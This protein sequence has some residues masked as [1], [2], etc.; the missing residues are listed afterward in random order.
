MNIM[1]RIFTALILFSITFSLT[2][3]T[4]GIAGESTKKFIKGNIADKTAAVREAS[5]SEVAW[6]SSKAIEFCLENKDILGSD[7]ELDGLAVAAVLSLSQETLKNADAETKDKIIS[8][9]TSLFIKFNK[10]STVQIAVIT[11]LV[12]L[13]DSL[14]S[15]AFTIVLNDFI[16]TNDIKTMDSGVFKASITALE[17]IG[18]SESF[19]ILYSMANDGRYNLYKREIETAA[20]SLIPTSMDE[21]I[22]L[23]NGADMKKISSI[24][25]LAKNNSKISAKNLC[26]ISEKVLIE[27][28]LLTENS[29]A[30]SAADLEVQLSA[31][32]VLDDNKWTRASSSALSY[33]ELSK[34]M[35]SKGLMK[36]DMFG[37]V[38]SSLRN[39]APLNAVTPLISYLEE[40]NSRTEAGKQVSSAVVLAVINTLGAIGDKSSFDS[41]LAVTYLGYEES[42]LTAA[43]QALSGLRWQ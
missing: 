3:Q 29:S 21:V 20:S 24:F 10:S 2:A 32:K 17:S 11:K 38:I 4:A 30:I 22:N 31:L 12:G 39:I 41:L 25:T 33:F 27:S 28:I 34:K 37:T 13:K 19:T 26:E 8:D 5:D 9:F 6:I 35:Y 42:V 1:R 14:P 7:R 18:N 43:R 36:E 15:E 16:K 40:L 23:I